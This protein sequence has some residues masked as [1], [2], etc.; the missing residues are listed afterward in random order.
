MPRALRAGLVGAEH[1][2]A[3]GVRVAGAAHATGEV[4][5]KVIVG[6]RRLAGDLPSQRETRM[7]SL[8]PPGCDT[9]P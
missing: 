7:R 2:H 1:H 8:R 4:N 9:V 5:P 3:D 6:H